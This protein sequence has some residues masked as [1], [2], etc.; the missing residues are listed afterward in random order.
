MSSRLNGTLVYNLKT[1][2]YAIATDFEKSLNHR[3]NH[4]N[5]FQ[6]CKHWKELECIC[7]QIPNSL[8]HQIPQEFS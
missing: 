8:T 5:S 6:F 1:F 3:S 7:F 2:I 4:S